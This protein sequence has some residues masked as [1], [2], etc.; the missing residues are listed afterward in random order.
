[1]AYMAIKSLEAQNLQ[2]AALV[3]E[4]STPLVKHLAKN[5]WSADDANDLAQEAFL[6]MHKFQQSQELDNAKAFLFTTVNNLAIDQL[7]RTKLHDK[8][9]LAESL[10]ENTK[11]DDFR[12]S[13]SPE[14]TVAA[15]QE[16]DQI[17]ALVEQM[18]TKVKAAFLLHRDQGLRYSQI[19]A[20]MGVSS[21][22]VEK[23]I[24]EALKLLRQEMPR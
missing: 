1:M 4:F 24:T 15:K 18:P 5:G 16:L 2:L 11:D 14:R 20:E 3:E 19:A 17:Y 21:S 23:Y 9:L 7:R 6:R 12:S 22:M 13:P 10:P 8:Y